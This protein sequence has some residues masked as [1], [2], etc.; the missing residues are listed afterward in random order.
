MPVSRAAGALIVAVTDPSDTKVLDA[1]R[2]ATGMTIEP[3]IA[4]A[5][6]I[7]AAHDAR[8]LH[9][10]AQ[11]GAWRLGHRARASLAIDFEWMPLV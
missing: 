9:D 1:L 7:R 8:D 5:D 4:S 3:V 2:G 10:R 6:E 11:R